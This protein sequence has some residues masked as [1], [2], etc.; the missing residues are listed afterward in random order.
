MI[1][2]HPDKADLRF[3]DE[4]KSVLVEFAKT[5]IRITKDDISETNWKRVATNILRDVNQVRHYAEQYEEWSMQCD[6][7]L[8]SHFEKVAIKY[9][10]ELEAWGYGPFKGVKT[11]DEFTAIYMRTHC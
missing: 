9:N 7:L 2:F 6:L 4:D 3:K 5:I 1:V 8:S 10:D 11:M